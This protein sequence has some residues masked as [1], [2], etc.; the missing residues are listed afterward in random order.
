MNAFVVRFVG[1]AL[2]LLAI[3]PAA[4]AQS[5]DSHAP[6]MLGAGVNKGNVDNITGSHFYYVWVGPGHVDVRM[7]FKEMGLFGAPLK[8]GLTF[9]FYDESGKQLLAHN[10]LVSLKDLKQAKTSGD[11]DSRQKLL[12]AVIPQKGAIRLGGYYEIEITGAAELG[13]KS[14][15]ASVAPQ[16]TALLNS[17]GPL[18]EKGGPLLE[19]GGPLLERGGPLLEKGGPLLNSGQSL[20]VNETAKE[21]R[22]TMAA[23]ILFDFDKATIRPDAASALHQIALLLREKSHGDVRIEGHTDSMGGND[24]NMRLSQRRALAVE[25]WLDEREG[26]AGKR[27]TIVGF[28][29]SR[30]VA[31]NRKPDGSDDPDGR[32]KNR[33]VELV[34]AK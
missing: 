2:L 15:T 17:S 5:L 26:F 22:V 10:L 18:L 12:L 6:A 27:F 21:L 3:M 11:F 20:I 4:H 30:P 33:R 23:D 28:G 9:D 29:A 13:G 8:Q 31:P 14:Q 25:S 19:K 32:Q 16:G 7:A 24:Y 1:V 34:I